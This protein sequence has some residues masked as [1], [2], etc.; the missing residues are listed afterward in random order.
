MASLL[1][2][3]VTDRTI[4][5][6]M[7]GSLREAQNLKD[8]LEETGDYRRVSIYQVRRGEGSMN[9]LDELEQVSP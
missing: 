1:L 6:L 7:L 8:F 3:G 9:E 4:N 2:I 5:R